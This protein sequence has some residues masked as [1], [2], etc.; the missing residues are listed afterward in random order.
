MCQDLFHYLLSTDGPEQKT[1]IFCVRDRHADDVATVM[2]NL[3]AQ[4]CQE[5]NFK[6]V[7][8]YAF[9]CTAKNA[10]STYL[11]DLKGSSRSH[12]IA[13]T[14]DLLTTGVDVPVVRNIVFFKYVNSPISFYQMVGRGTRLDAA[15]GKLM[16][17]VYDYTNATR[18]FAQSFLSRLTARRT[19]TGEEG[20]SL[21]TG[22]QQ[23]QRTI[24]VEGFD[25]KI[26]PAGRYILT[27]VDGEA[28]PVTIEEYKERLAQKLVETVPNLTAFRSI[29]V[30]REERRQAIAQLPD[31]GR[32]ALL[33]RTVEDL[34]DC[35]LYDVLAELAYG[36]NRRTRVE[37]VE[38]FAYKH[39]DWLNE[40]PA[41]TAA[42]VKALTAQFT[43][44]GT[45]G[46]DNS[47]IFQTPKVIPI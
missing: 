46:L 12:L 15:T 36:L 38:A 41:S 37:R 47:M 26:T 35:D 17:R 4:W 40:M 42:T 39:V 31:G 30:N 33:V 32:S 19:F 28:L 6:R 3:Y 25:V 45:E 23:A 14:V 5:N 21:P 10:G 34:E 27:M 24:L 8:P 16:F 22:E 2:N 44:A 20:I 11:A 43:R 9:K 13:T 29:W 7:E 1:I 18:L